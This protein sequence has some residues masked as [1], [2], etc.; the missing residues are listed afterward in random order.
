MS[1]SGFFKKNYKQMLHCIAGN[2]KLAKAE[3]WGEFWDLKK[4][5][6]VARELT[7]GKLSKWA[8]FLCNTTAL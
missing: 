3:S 2:R 5:V 6:D 4:R 8:F 1:D 7:K